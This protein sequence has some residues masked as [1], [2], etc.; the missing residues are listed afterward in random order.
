VIYAGSSEVI[1]RV[2]G[3]VPPGTPKGYYILCFKDSSMY[4]STNTGGATF[5]VE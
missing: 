1:G 3:T 5:T 2:R 4:Q